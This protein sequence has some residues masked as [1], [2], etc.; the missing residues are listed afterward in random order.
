VKI[1][2]RFLAIIG[3]A[4]LFGVPPAAVSKQLKPTELLVRRYDKL[5]DEGALLTPEGWKKSSR[6]WSSSDPYPQNG[7]IVIQDLGGLMAEDWVKDNRA[8]VETKWETSYGTI[9]SS[10]RYK[11]ELPGHGGILMGRILT[12]VC[13]D[14]VKNNPLNA[15][16]ADTSCA[17]EWKLEGPQH[18]RI[19]SV[20][21][22]L[23]YVTE[24]RDKTTDLAI[25]KNAN[26][27]IEILKRLN[28]GR[29][30]ACAC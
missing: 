1:T 3:C 8:Q 13:V 10:L 30:T 12:L 11:S 2:H 24:M 22:V 21:A 20:A 29:G 18:S 4:A 5:V 15:H 23:K 9:D 17:G 6:L 25:R 28:R 26:R 14:S 16:I 7:E 19:A 27:T